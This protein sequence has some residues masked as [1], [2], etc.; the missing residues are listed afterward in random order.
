MIRMPDR[1]LAEIVRL[2]TKHHLSQSDV[3][4]AAIGFSLLANRNDFESEL[5]T[6]EIY[7]GTGPEMEH[8]P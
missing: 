8:Q 4:R 6:I 3:I 5:D 7:L 2:A 1:Y